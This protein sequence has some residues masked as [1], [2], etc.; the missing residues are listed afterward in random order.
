MTELYKDQI[1][2]YKEAFAVFDQDG[3]GKISKDELR[4]IMKALG[5]NPTETDLI[6]YIKE[7]DKNGNGTI[8]FDEFVEVMKTRNCGK[9]LIGNDEALIKSFKVFDQNGDGFISAQELKIVMAE[10]GD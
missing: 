1:V 5:Q 2:A 8:D 10:L 3:D 4:E 7:C 6:E 9:E